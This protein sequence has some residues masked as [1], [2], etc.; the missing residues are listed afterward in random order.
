MCV[1]RTGCVS[2]LAVLGYAPWLQLVRD[3]LEFTYW[4][5]D[6]TYGWRVFLQA[7]LRCWAGKHSRGVR[8]CVRHPRC[9]TILVV[10]RYHS[11]SQSKLCW[12]LGEVGFHVRLA[13]ISTTERSTMERESEERNCRL[14]RSVRVGVLQPRCETTLVVLGHQFCMQITQAVL[15][16]MYEKLDFSDGWREFLPTEA[17]L[18][19]ESQKR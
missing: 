7:E 19:K 13:R 1:L 6:F 17:P 3:V 18:W 15:N 4:K 2:P 14:N 12:I 11:C 10:L 5:L 8:V 16:F 9:V